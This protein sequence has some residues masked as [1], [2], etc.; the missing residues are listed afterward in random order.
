MYINNTMYVKFK[1]VC[2][3][4][5]RRPKMY[6][7]YVGFVLCT[8]V[9]FSQSGIMHHCIGAFKSYKKQEATKKLFNSPKFV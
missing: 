3:I 4:M 1:S 6:W 7:V 5:E 9:T 8:L 2:F